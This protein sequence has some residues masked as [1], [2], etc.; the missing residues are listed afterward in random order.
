M[1][2]RELLEKILKKIGSMDSGMNSMESKISSMDSRMNS[3][4]SKISSMETKMTDI[5]A[6]VI[7][8]KDIVTKIEN[9]HGQML[10]VLFDGYTQNS[11]KLDRI[12]IEVSK[13]EEI[14]LKKLK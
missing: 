10:G 2:D 8:T 5:K 11:E 13:H 14:I 9:E 1:T 6:A 3:M 4:E 12:E 7:F